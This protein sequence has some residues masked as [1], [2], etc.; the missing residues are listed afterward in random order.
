MGMRKCLK[1]GIHTVA[2]SWQLFSRSLEARHRKSFLGYFWLVFPSIVI[3]SGVSLASQSGVINPGAT[4]L[5]YFL[6]VLIGAL[7]W[8]VFVEALDVPCQ[9]FEEARSYLTRIS[10]TREA[11]I[12]AQFYEML[13]NMF[14]RLGMVWVLIAWWG[15]ADWRCSL[16]MTVCFGGAGVLGLGIGA[17]LM[18]FMLL[19]SDLHHAVKLLLSY[20]VFLTPAFYAPGD[21]GVFSKVVYWTP[22]APLMTSARDAAAGV[23][24]SQA[25]GLLWVLAT[26]IV[27][28]CLGLV[29]VRLCAPI[30]IERML[31]GGR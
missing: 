9:A 30:V 16:L 28:T 12:L 10:F 7:I 20:G 1:A 8:Q 6:F 23:T 25:D 21:Q 14:V 11:V 19:L 24:L 18:P 15:G 5:P 17:L 26:S 22:V 4:R 31:L 29:F 3:A 13:L 27:L 2:L